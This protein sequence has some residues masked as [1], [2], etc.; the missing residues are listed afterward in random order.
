MVIITSVAGPIMWYLWIHSG[1][2]NANYYFGMT[3]TYSLAQIFLLL[4]VIHSFLLHQYD[5]YN[6][7]PRLDSNGKPIYLKLD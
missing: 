7:L 6:G 4:D 5:L 1:S 2:A 3:L